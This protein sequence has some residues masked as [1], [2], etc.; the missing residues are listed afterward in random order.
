M[1][2]DEKLSRTVIDELHRAQHL[3]GP[4]QSHHEGF[5]VIQEEVDEL[6]DCIKKGNFEQAAIEARQISAMGM[7][8]ILDLYA[9]NL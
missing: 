2:N 8:Y 3:H 6:W 4:I 7:R 9:V 5:A 1:T